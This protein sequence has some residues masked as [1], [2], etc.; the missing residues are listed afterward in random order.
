MFNLPSGV[1]A[2]TDMDPV[3]ITS[4]T[5]RSGT[6][7]LQRLLC[8]APKGFI[9]GEN[10]AQDL[11]LFLRVYFSKSLMY[12]FNKRQFAETLGAFIN[13][14]PQGWIIDLM[15]D[16]DEYLQTLSRSCLAG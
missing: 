5:I 4:P 7:L 2:M 9:F 8:S 11:E 12:S 15:P 13:G 16:I 1:L 6:T 14:Q 10:C 3:I